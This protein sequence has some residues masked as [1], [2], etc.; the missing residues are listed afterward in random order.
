QTVYSILSS[1]N[2]K[3]YYKYN[4][5]P[6]KSQKKKA[7]NL[8]YLNEPKIIQKLIDFED[9]EHTMVTFYIPAIHCSSCIWLL[10]NLYKLNPDI[11]STRVDFTKKQAN[12]KFRHQNISL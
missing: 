6:G 10:E 4:Q 5:H 11:L 3:N 12:I 7:E 2:L 9:D 8:D 1:N